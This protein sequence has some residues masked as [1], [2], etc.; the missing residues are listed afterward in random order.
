MGN[1]SLSETE[2]LELFA[3][4]LRRRVP[5]GWSVRRARSQA[6]GPW[7]PDYLYD[8]GPA[9]G[10]TGRLAVEVKK[11]LYPR[12]V[13]SQRL[14]W[15]ALDRQTPVLVATDYISPRT[16]QVLEEADLNFADATGTL[17][18]RL[19]EPLI[20]IDVQ[21]TGQAP[22]QPAG[23]R[24]L[25]SLR[26]PASGRGVRALSD[27]QPPYGVRELATRA[28]LAPATVSRLF[29]LLDREALIEHDS[30]RSPVKSVDWA[31]LLRRWAQDYRFDTSNRI[32]RFIEPR[33][34]PTLFAKLRGYDRRY[35]V[36]GS[37]A[38]SRWAPVAP[39]RLATLFVEDV[40]RAGNELKLTPTETG[41]NVVLAEPFD[42]VAFERTQLIDGVRYAAPSQ[43]AADLLT[44]PGR[45]PQEAEALLTWMGKN[46][47]AWRS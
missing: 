2:L 45:A 42:R 3:Q 24:E 14:L 33:T 34:L 4:E 36:T 23:R 31:A 28:G 15:R 46:E 47:R 22:R 25:Q 27:F 29:D 13:V 40:E 21:G 9:N 18:L 37:F 17:R 12:D 35:A 7:R 26:T 16:R 5:A 1:G 30:P 43:V 32:V 44:G 11:R 8:V 39:P 20:V 6:R 38:A 10:P 19:K 41:I